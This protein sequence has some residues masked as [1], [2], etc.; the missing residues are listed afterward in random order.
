MRESPPYRPA[1][2]SHGCQSARPV[3]IPLRRDDNR[4]KSKMSKPT[5]KSS[6]PSNTTLNIVPRRMVYSPA[7]ATCDVHVGSAGI[8]KPAIASLIWAIRALSSASALSALSSVPRRKREPVAR[9]VCVEHLVVLLDRP[10]AFGYGLVATLA[11][12]GCY[13]PGRAVK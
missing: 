8:A 4:A 1:T 6:T 10:I 2:C 11:L 5:T 12:L 3:L 7:A 9:K 13:V